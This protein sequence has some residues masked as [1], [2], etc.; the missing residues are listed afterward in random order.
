MSVLLFVLLLAGLF[1]FFLPTAF[2]VV[3]NR[4]VGPVFLVN[5]L[6][7]WTFIGW[8]IAIVWA[9]TERT[10]REE[11]AYNVRRW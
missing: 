4:A 10:E 9:F 5:L 2:A 7:G 11:H 3:R 8:V 6:V 1:L